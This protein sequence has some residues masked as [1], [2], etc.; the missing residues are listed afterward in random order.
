MRVG[1]HFKQPVCRSTKLIEFNCA[2]RTNT[3]PIA[4][5]NQ[6]SKISVFL[7]SPICFPSSLRAPLSSLLVHGT[8]PL[9]HFHKHKQAEQSFAA[10]CSVKENVH[11]SYFEHVARRLP[12][13]NPAHSREEVVTQFRQRRNTQ[14]FV[15]TPDA[16]TIGRRFLRN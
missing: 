4:L 13:D 8:K 14:L 12:S 1:V 3:R 10:R 7:F 9:G 2:R 16:Q 11:V 15:D 5:K 6:K